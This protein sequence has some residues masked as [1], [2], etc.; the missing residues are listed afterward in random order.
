MPTFGDVRRISLGL[1][2]TNEI[3]TW[4]TD[5]TFRVG[6]R[7]F[8]ISGEGADRVSIKATLAAQAE[9]ID[10]DPLIFGRAAYVG[11]FGWITV[12]LA[13]VDPEILAG[14]LVAGWRLPA[15]KRLAATRPSPP[16]RANRSPINDE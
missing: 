3:L 2:E 1:P 14:L 13:R 15:P 7:I 9:L 16:V 11:R 6:A 5:A 4:G 12:D 8:A 10:L